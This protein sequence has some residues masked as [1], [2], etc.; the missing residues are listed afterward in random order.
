MVENPPVAS[1]HFTHNVNDLCSSSS[2]SCS[3]FL[4]PDPCL[5]PR[6][7]PTCVSLSISLTFLTL[8]LS[9]FVPSSFLSNPA[10][11][12]SSFIPS[13]VYLPSLTV[14]HSLAHCLVSLIHPVHSPV[15]PSSPPPLYCTSPPFFVYLTVSLLK[16]G[17]HGGLTLIDASD[18]GEEE[19]WLW[20]DKVNSVFPSSSSPGGN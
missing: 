19:G 14:Y 16:P 3:P 12:E 17:G 15:N 8:L 4:P 7:S 13:P 5:L 6:F 18:R 20:A 11:A 2:L 9:A 1:V 10:R